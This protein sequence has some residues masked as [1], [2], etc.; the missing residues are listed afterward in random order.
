[1]VGNSLFTK[2]TR[3]VRSFW[4]LYRKYCYFLRIRNSFK[5]YFSNPTTSVLYRLAT[6]AFS[7]PCPG[8]TLLQINRSCETNK[9]QEN[10]LY[11]LLKT[12]FSHLRISNKAL[13]VKFFSNN[14]AIRKRHMTMH[15]TSALVTNL[16]WP[17][18]CLNTERIII[19]FFLFLEWNLSWMLVWCCSLFHCKQ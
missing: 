19:I 12:R 3:F 13:F 1:M 8:I 11:Q 16:H 2:R 15:A 10:T 7:V 18:Y 14:S 5:S 6:W 17:L 4:A 9:V